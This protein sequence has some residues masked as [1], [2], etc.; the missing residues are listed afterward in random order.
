MEKLQLKTQ[1]KRTLCVVMAHLGRGSPSPHSPAFPGTL[2]G[3]LEQPTLAAS[4]DL[5]QDNNYS[6]CQFCLYSI[7]PFFGFNIKIYF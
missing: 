4:S 3:T 7:D 5:L 1:W 2:V 6:L